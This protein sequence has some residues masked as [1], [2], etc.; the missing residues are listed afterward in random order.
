MK[1]KCYVD[2]SYINSDGS[3][4]I[5]CLEKMSLGKS[6]EI[7]PKLTK[8]QHE[9]YCKK[10]HKC[11]GPVKP[12]VINET[13][14]EN[15][16]EKH[17]HHR[18]Y[19]HEDKATSIADYY[20]AKHPRSE[21]VLVTLCSTTEASECGYYKEV[22]TKE[23]E[24]IRKWNG[25]ASSTISID[26]YI[27]S[28]APELY[29]RLVSNPSLYALDMVENIDLDNTRK[30]SHCQIREYDGE[31]DKYKVYNS[32]FPLND[33]EFRE[34]L[35]DRISTYQS[36]T[37]NS[38]VVYHPELAQKIMRHLICRT[39]MKTENYNHFMVIFTE[40]DQ[41]FNEIIKNKKDLPDDLQIYLSFRKILG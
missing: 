6:M 17:T 9:E 23:K 7:L 12:V 24:F 28:Q 13:Y 20:I 41:S 37:M 26:E 31:T 27:A 5:E 34:L 3:L 1:R 25:S 16:V 32:S 30:Y 4:N 29:Q 40:I 14:E 11:T 8:E 35:I 33:D 39:G 21:F 18:K 22:T 36:L 19:R 15:L 10:A 38:V 2:P